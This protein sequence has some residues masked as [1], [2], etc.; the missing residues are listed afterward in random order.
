MLK[1]VKYNVICRHA[2]MYCMCKCIRAHDHILICKVIGRYTHTYMRYTVD[3]TLHT[4]KY[5]LINTLCRPLYI[6]HI[7]TLYTFINIDTQ[8]YMHFMYIH[9]HV[10]TYLC[11]HLKEYPLCL[12]PSVF[13][14]N[15]FKFRLVH[16]SCK[17]STSDET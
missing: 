13:H 14:V 11:A 12:K 9:V 16:S 15:A 6:K 4:Y 2:F 17:S 5:K 8:I 3:A 1:E 10:F 7:Y